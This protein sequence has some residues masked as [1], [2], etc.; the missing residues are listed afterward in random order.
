M[1]HKLS[2]SVRDLKARRLL[3]AAVIAAMLGLAACGGGDKKKSDSVM[4]Q[5]TVRE[6]ALVYPPFNFRS[7]DDAPWWEIFNDSNKYQYKY[8]EKLGI[9]PVHDLGKAYYTSKPLIKIVDNKNYALDSL[10]HSFPYLVENASTL[11]DTIGADFIARL[12]QKGVHGV[13]MKVTSLLRTAA[14]VKKLRRVNVNAT[15]SSCHK[16]GTT[17]DISY[18]GF[19]KSPGATQVDDGVLKKTLA[20]VLFDLRRQQKCMVKYER[21][22]HC[23]HVTV[24]H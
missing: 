12:K 10:T 17:F 21:K 4:T 14:S 8:A 20:E 1:E 5:E 2:R 19:I 9:E 7:V 16:F 22:T 23:F 6:E 18:A 13:R 15:D 3:P 24:T 11:L